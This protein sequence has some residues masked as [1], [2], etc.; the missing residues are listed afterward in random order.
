MINNDSNN[1]NYIRKKVPKQKSKG[2]AKKIIVI[3]F[4]TK[5]K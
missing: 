4:E 3:I 1:K 2:E 5:Y